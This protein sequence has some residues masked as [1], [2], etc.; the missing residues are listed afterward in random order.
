M[1]LRREG[2]S[3]GR[4]GVLFKKRKGERNACN[5]RILRSG[6]GMYVVVAV[7]V[8]VVDS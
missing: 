6:E 4:E 5:G 2:R 1:R 8:V 3:E 7:V